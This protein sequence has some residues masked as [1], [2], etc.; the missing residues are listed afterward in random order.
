MTRSSEERLI[1]PSAGAKPRQKAVGGSFP[2]SAI[3][4]EVAERQ[5]VDPLL[6][7]AIIQVESAFIARVRSPHGA[8]GLMQISPKVAARYAVRDPYDPAANIEAGIL[9][10]KW[11][12]S[13]FELP[14]ALAA[15]NA[16]DGAVAQWGGR[17]P[18]YRET[19]RFVQQV[20]RL[21]QR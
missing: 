14:V 13:K 3:V 4:Y 6:I 7:R 5:G 17:V 18:P 8:M 9:H 12:L 10:L 15:Y 19:R 21:A 2:Y 1:A 11:L 20:L 16:G